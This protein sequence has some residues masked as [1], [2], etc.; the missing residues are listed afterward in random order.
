MPVGGKGKEVAKG[1]GKEVGELVFREQ[2]WK[3]DVSA[4]A[5]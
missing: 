2:F 5:G 4:W 3:V 1:R